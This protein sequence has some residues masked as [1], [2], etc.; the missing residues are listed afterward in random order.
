VFAGVCGGL[1]EYFGVD[2][3]LL[4]I[5]AVALALSGGA[6]LLLYV[7]A[8]IA[9]PEQGSANPNPEPGRSSPLRPGR[10]GEPCPPARGGRH[11]RRGRA[12]RGRRPH[13]AQTG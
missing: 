6:G 12:G 10:G 13:A 7:I 8:W 5:V 1:A 3:V 2:A 4:R 9:I 11:R